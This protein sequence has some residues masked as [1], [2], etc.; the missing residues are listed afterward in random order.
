MSP[1]PRR[2]PWPQL[3]VASVLLFASCRDRVIGPGETEPGEPE[4]PAILPV[5]VVEITLNAIGTDQFTATATGLS[6]DLKRP[7]NQDSTGSGNVQL[8]QVSTGSFTEGTRGVDGQRYLYATFRVR[9][10]QTSAGNPAYNTPRT[11]LTFLAI[12]TANSKDG[13]AASQI[14]RFDNSAATPTIASQV[15][16]TGAVALDDSLHMTS[17][18][19]D[20]LQVFTEQEVAAVPLPTG[21]LE[22]FPYGFVTRNPNNATS[23]T[24]PANPAPNQFDGRVTFAFR[25]PLQP[26]AV[27][28]VY[29]VTLQ[30]LAVDDSQ[31]RMTES[32]EEQDSASHVRARQRAL[33]IGASVVVLNGSPFSDYPGQGQLCGS[34]VANPVAGGVTRINAPGAYSRIAA[35]GPGQ[36]HDGCAARFRTGVF[37]PL[38]GSVLGLNIRY[39]ITLRALDRY[40]N[41]KPVADTVAL[42]VTDSGA[43]LPP[44]VRL[45]AGVGVDSIQV[46]SYGPTNATHPMQLIAAGRRQGGRE[47]LTVGGVKRIWNAGA[48][49]TNWTTGNNWNVRAAPAALD[50]V[51]VPDTVPSGIYP[52][53]I[54]NESVFGVQVL[55]FT[56]GGN[57]P[58]I[59]LGAFNLTAAGDVLT[60]NN[61][62]ITNSSGSLQLNGV[63]RTVAGKVP[64]VRVNGSY[65]MVG[66]LDARA[67]L[68]VVAG[69]LTDASFRLTVLSN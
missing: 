9:N 48:G 66:N 47:L 35:Y 58:S 27:D 13:S 11:N 4:K 67:P 26:N 57:T 6:L 61:G 23:R 54:Q 25:V 5:G 38:T 44:S 60:T 10:A 30:F 20:V 33:A 50:T 46:G 53:L 40:G 69:R 12:R 28:D 55:D 43:T 19:A 59:A 37:S 24:L 31:T 1:G 32:I 16:P 36:S 51:I 8:E 39:P 7:A 63:A 2:I 52:A 65:S 64:R 14:R 68:D 34:R 3:L 41:V 62:S 45:V 56:P 18:H 22:I 21:V 17:L 49:T 29:S 15:I 42:A